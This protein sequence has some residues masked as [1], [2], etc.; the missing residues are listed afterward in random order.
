MNMRSSGD[1]P[2]SMRE[3][4]LDAALEEFCKK[5]YL[6]GNMRN[7]AKRAKIAVGTIYKYFPS[8]RELYK[9]VFLKKA[10]TVLE[11]MLKVYEEEIT[12]PKEKLRKLLE[13]KFLKLLEYRDFIRLHIR[14]FWESSIV[15]VAFKEFVEIYER[16]IN[17]IAD[18]LSKINKKSLDENIVNANLISRVLAFFLLEI[19]MK[20][21]NY[22]FSDIWERLKKPLIEE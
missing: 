19:I 13:V 1:T 6:R 21:K 18:L 10:E 5:G 20:N 2:K 8:K 22:S 16:Q 15:G 17:L 3:I 14:E 7:I 9:Q 4:I 11:E 12:D